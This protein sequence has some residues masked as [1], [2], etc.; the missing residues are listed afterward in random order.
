MRY[1]VISLSLLMSGVLTAQNPSVYT[2]EKSDNSSASL[3]VKNNQGV[4]HLS[5]P[6]SSE[7]GNNFS[8]FWHD[9]SYYRRY[10]SI[11]DNG[12]IGLGTSSP[13]AKLH[14]YNGSSYGNTHPFADLTVEDD[15][16]GMINILT[17][18]NDVGYYGFSDQDDDFVGGI[19]YE[20]ASD[21]MKF[22]VNN[23]DSDMVIN[24]NGVVGIGTT[25]PTHV[26]D[27]INQSFGPEALLRLRVQ[28]APQDYF[29]ITNS[30]G[31]TGQF[32]PR[33][34]GHRISD[35]RYSVQFMGTTLESNDN[36]GN[37]L[38]NFDARRTNGPIQNRPLFLWTNYTTKMMT[39]LANG[40]LGIGTTNPGTYKL[41]VNGKIR[42]KEIKVETGW[43]DFVFE[44]D[45]HLPTLS[46]VESHIQEKGHLKDIPS[47]KEV[48]ENGIF[49]G[50][51]DAK[52]LQKIEELMLY[53]IAQEKQLK[54]Q[55][56]ENKQLKDKNQEL[57]ARLAK[58]EKILLPKN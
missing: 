35:N 53:T 40:N 42:A 5:G 33:V 9:G 34:A 13:Q 3:N 57:E 20:H 6:R 43:A 21:R 45:Y 27:V 36:G 49:L 4:W 19:Q 28:D 46:E 16:R 15:Y 26:L 52:L 37:A 41:A 23:H 48:A 58:L 51:M 10:M 56:T 12:N 50:E 29:S 14:I 38:V 8:I 55:Q 1:L 44:K 11:I 2:A 30:T 47:A 31:S 7:N 32:I 39:M 54:A 18:N 22:R 17:R 24:S 25:S